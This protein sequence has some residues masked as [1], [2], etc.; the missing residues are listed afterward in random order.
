MKSRDWLALGLLGVGGYVLYTKF[1]PQT[2]DATPQPSPSPTIPTI[3]PFFPQIPTQNIDWSK[4]I[5]DW[6]QFFPK[7]TPTPT[8]TPNVSYNTGPFIPVTTTPTSATSTSVTYGSATINKI[9]TLPSV[10]PTSI[11]GQMVS[12]NPIGLKIAS[13]PQ[14]TTATSSSW[15]TSTVSIPNVQTGTVLGQTATVIRYQANNKAGYID[16]PK[17]K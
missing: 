15:R 7:T 9:P 4:L 13:T 6:S 10:T 3:I 5:P 16:V 2:Q 1:K 14:S 11:W 12:N 8:T 17:K